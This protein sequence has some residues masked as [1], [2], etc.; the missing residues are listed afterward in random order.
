MGFL[1]TSGPPADRP[2]SK[3]R[4]PIAA[5]RFQI[6]CTALPQVN[7]TTSPHVAAWAEL[8]HQGDV[9]C[10]LL[11][12]ADQIPSTLMPILEHVAGEFLPMVA[13]YQQALQVYI[14]VGRPEPGDRLPRFVGDATFPMADAQFTRRAM[15]YTLWMMQRLR[16]K[17]SALSNEDQHTAYRWFDDCFATRIADIDLGPRLIRD[18]LSTIL[19]R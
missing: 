16:D 4:E 9:A 18:G 19:G 5:H 7:A 10:G 15:P 14:E 1:T 12:E 17:M 13:A 3:A 6:V 2:L 11:A 8:A